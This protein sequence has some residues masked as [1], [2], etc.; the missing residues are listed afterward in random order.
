MVYAAYSIGDRMSAS[1]LPDSSSDD[2]PT[3]IATG[4]LAATLAAVCHETLGHGLAC[5]AVGGHIE[6]LTSIWFRC[7]KFAPI[8]DAGG[9]LGNLVAGSLA[10]LLLGHTKPSP[11]VR[12]LLLMFGALNVFWFMGQLTFESLTRTRD[13]WYWF[14]GTQPGIGRLLA[15]V[16]GIG[17]YV[18][19]IRWLTAILGKQGGPPGDAIL[20]AYGAAAVSAVIA[21]LMWRPEPLRSAVEGFATLGITS[22]G[23]LLAARRVRRP[24]GHDVGAQSV[25]RSWAWIYFCA[26]CFGIFLLL[27][28]RGMGPMVTSRL[29]P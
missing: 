13:D 11:T 5:L 26:V 10:I 27:Q 20:L 12:L 23:L 14:L 9:P 2:A 7:S 22:F 28:A 8:A 25:P 1:V 21:G 4:A 15:A 24:A 18:L 19:A 6:L 16:M 3:V 29:S 17:G